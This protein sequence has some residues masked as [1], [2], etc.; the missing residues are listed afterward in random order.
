MGKSR[1]DL[2]IEMCGTALIKN[3]P[4]HQLK[5]LSK[6]PQKDLKKMAEKIY[7]ILE[8]HMKQLFI[9]FFIEEIKRGD[10]NEAD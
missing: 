6:M 9:K 10:N 3:M 5:K 4:E 2:F 1:I 7:E 8:E